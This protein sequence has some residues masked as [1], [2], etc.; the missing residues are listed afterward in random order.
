MKKKFWLL[1]ILVFLFANS[2]FCNTAQ[3]NYEKSSI[4]IDKIEESKYQSACPVLV[5][6]TDDILLGG[7]LNSDCSF[8]CGGGGGGSSGFSALGQITSTAFAFGA[9][10]IINSTNNLNTSSNTETQVLTCPN[11]NLKDDLDDEEL[12]K[13]ADDI[14][15]KD[16]DYGWNSDELV[17]TFKESINFPTT[18]TKAEYLEYRNTKLRVYLGRYNGDEP[19]KSYDTIAKEENGT[20]FSMNDLKWK[21][22]ESNHKGGMWLLNKMFLSYCISRDCTFVLLTN[23]DDYYNPWLKTR[24]KA[25]KDTYYTSEL[26]FINLNGYEWDMYEFKESLEVNRG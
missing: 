19:E 26:E 13:L 22:Y 6:T 16:D 11:Y 9:V 20:F 1:F 2:I 24:I 7:I 18:N 8:G 15:S 23:P 12:K 14:L 10:G 5:R 4:E 25:N 17:A 21:D 3:V